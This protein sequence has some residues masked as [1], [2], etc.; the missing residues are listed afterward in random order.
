MC[1]HSVHFTIILNDLG[2]F[3][4]LIKN[5]S[6]GGFQKC[7]RFT[8]KAYKVC[9]SGSN[10]KYQ[11]GISSGICLLMAKQALF[12]SSVSLLYYKFKW[13]FLSMILLIVEILICLKL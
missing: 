7:C 1:L 9:T 6:L 10:N 3:E 11:L 5:M 4:Q 2:I 12:S 13:L 8:R